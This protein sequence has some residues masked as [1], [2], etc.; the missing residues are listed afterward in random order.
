MEKLACQ[1]ETITTFSHDVL[2]FIKSLLSRRMFCLST[3]FYKL[4]LG[5]KLG[6][7]HSVHSFKTNCLICINS[8]R[9]GTLQLRF[10][11]KTFEWKS[12]SGKSFETLNCG[13]Y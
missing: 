1:K 4:V 12:G 13:N 11:C 7:W 5:R 2:H 9:R 3:I 10:C 6:S 8:K